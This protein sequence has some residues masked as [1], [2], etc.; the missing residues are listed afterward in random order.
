MPVAL[1][2]G[3][4]PFGK[5]GGERGVEDASGVKLPALAGVGSVGYGKRRQVTGFREGRAP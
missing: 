4:Y 1:G 2:D 5:C 3:L